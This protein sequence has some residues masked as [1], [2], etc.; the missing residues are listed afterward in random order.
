MEDAMVMGSS[1]EEGRSGIAEGSGGGVEDI[2][3]LLWSGG[4][5]CGVVRRDVVEKARSVG[6]ETR[7]KVG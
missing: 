7:L 4:C 5:V 1:G 3:G 2:S 6:G